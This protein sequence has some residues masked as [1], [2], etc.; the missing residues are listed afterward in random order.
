MAQQE[1]YFKV[2]AGHGN[3]IAAWDNLTAGDKQLIKDVTGFDMFADP[4]GKML[5]SP[6]VQSF[7]GRLNMDRYS[8]SHYGNSSGL[9]GGEITGSYINKLIQE[10][11]SAMPGQATVLLPILY[12]VQS[13]LATQPN[14]TVQA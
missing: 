12:K 4:F 14:G 2:E 5:S 8:D 6:E 3:G 10:N 7:I 13:Y 9:N 1:Q 11:F